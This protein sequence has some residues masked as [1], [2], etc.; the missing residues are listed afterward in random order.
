MNCAV[1][2]EMNPEKSGS[3]S[4]AHQLH[5]A[6]PSILKSS[7][8]TR[9]VSDFYSTVIFSFQ[10]CCLCFCNFSICFHV[11]D[12]IV[13]DKEDADT[14]SCPQDHLNYSFSQ[15]FLRGKGTSATDV[16][17]TPHYKAVVL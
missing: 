11:F 12:V 5:A 9:A 10:M 1:S 14:E 3:S 2:V 7:L 6:G 15:V 16:Q 8:S 13:S 4:A 17:I